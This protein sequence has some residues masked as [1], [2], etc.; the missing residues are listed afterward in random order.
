MNPYAQPDELNVRHTAIR[1]ESESKPTRRRDFGATDGSLHLT[2]PMIDSPTT[3]TAT[4]RHSVFIVDDHPLVREGLGQLIIQAPD[5]SVSGYA[6][7]T[8]TAYPEIVRLKPEI[9][10]IDL[11][12]RGESGLELI[13][14]LQLL[15]EPPR[16]LV[17]SM[18][19][20]A[21]YAE[22]ALR[23]GALG[24]VMKRESPSKVID[25][26]RQVISGRIFV[27]EA[28]TSEVMG[29]FVGAPTSHDE[30]LV[31]RLSDREMEIFRKMG[32]GQR[33]R[34]IADELHISLKTVQTHCM[35]IK[36]KLG[37]TDATMLMREAVRWVENERRI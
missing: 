5:L 17:L 16:M 15:P 14:R 25:A 19:D 26:I 27:S 29:K 12:L 28:I 8:A 10:V 11:A 4:A 2:Q 6:E 22:R 37:I 24:Y 33:T 13:K 31:E 21:F 35:H 32:N 18:H 36:E 34:T 1:K 23:A 3:E 30:P 9:V 20:E 7:D